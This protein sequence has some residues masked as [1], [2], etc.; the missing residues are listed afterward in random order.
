[1]GRGGLSL[2]LICLAL[3]IPATLTRTWADE[4]DKS[5]LG[6][7]LSRA[8]STPSSR[9]AIGAVDGALS[10]DATIR[11]VAVSDRD[12]VW[13]KL[14]KARIVW[15]RLALLSGRL[16]VDSLEIGQLE[17][18]RRPVPGPTPPEAKPDGKLLPDLPVKV[19]IKDFRLAELVLGAAVAGQPAR[20]SAE[21]RARLGAASEG[22]ELKARAQRLDAA[23]RFL[24]GLLYVPNG[25]TLELKAN[26]VEPAGGLLSKAANLP[27]TPPINFD[28]DGTGT[29]DAWSAKLDFAAGPEIGA[30]GGAKIS[31]IGAERRLALDLAARIEG[32]VPGPAA[33][34][35]AGTT[36]L[37]GGLAFADS[38]AF[39][40]DRLELTSRTARLAAGGSLSADRV[41]DLTLQ[42][43]ALPTDGSVTK[44]GEA[45]IEKLVFDGSL[46]GPIATPTIRGSLDAAGLRS[47][48][49]S[50]RR[51]ASPSAR[52]ARCR[53]CGSPI[54]PCGGR[55]E[56]GRSS[57]SVRGPGRT[58]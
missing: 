2:V 37:A 27:G 28:L 6:G 11:D 5:V 15:R 53:A 45:E 7:L 14:D 46:K 44:A 39:R 8:L 30:K 52:M 10:S 55:S 42:A 32:L 50:P 57:R 23:G 13:L 4:G 12:G 34:V 3:L 21:G 20:L 25:D 1:M 19:E 36:Q 41:A 51:S 18:L 24:L 40:I 43:R 48:R 22:L 26:L 16:E 29:L 54:R 56:A 35:F 17:V 47:R 38:S 58:G 49:A 31:R 9:V 33:S